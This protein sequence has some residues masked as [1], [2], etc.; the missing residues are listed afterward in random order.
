MAK[1]KVLFIIG[2]QNQTT[3]M[4]QI[5]NCLTDDFDCYFST[6][7]GDGWLKKF[8]ELG[9]VEM[10]ILGSKVQKS[11]IEYCKKHHLQVDYRGEKNDYDL[12]FAC[13]DLAIPNNI[14]NSKIV[15]VQEG[16]LEPVDWRFYTAK[17][18]N[19]P[20]VLADS[21]M[22]GLS[23]MYSYFCVMSEGY[24]QEF[25]KRGAPEDKLIVTGTPNFD[26]V[27]IYEKNTFPHKNYVL[28]ATSNHRETKRSDD[29]KGFIKKV[30]KIANGRKI[31][32][33]LHPRE[34]VKRATKEIRKY[35]PQD[36][37]IFS[38]G[39]T[40]EMLANCDV[41]VTTY[42]TVILTAAAL[43]KEIHCDYSEA[44]IKAYTPVQTGG[45]S[46]QAIADIG[47]SLVV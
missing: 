31:I 22:T 30:V 34:D 21:A 26:H 2:T 46:A 9:W 40:N 25:I 37:L 15:L 5:K 7:Y 12:V 18:L 19:L 38:D 23:G 32:F 16:I 8:T 24:K 10:T 43:G 47:M 33:K 13:Q 4:H 14:R 6:F 41:L 17:A 35:A 45:T 29:R 11:N 1:K 42:S 20:R 44:Q 28:A 39:N 36:T 3:M 27:E